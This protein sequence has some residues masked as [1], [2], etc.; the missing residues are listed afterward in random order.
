MRVDRGRLEADCFSE[1][2]F[3]LLGVP[4]AHANGAKVHE[5]TALVR[6]NLQRLLNL[7]DR[8]CRIFERG[9]GVRT[10]EERV[11]VFRI[12][13]QQRRRT[14]LRILEAASKEQDL[15][16]LDL[17]VAIVWQRIR[18]SN[19]LGKGGPQVVHPLVRFRE[20]Q[21]RFTELRIEPHRVGVFDDRK[22]VA[23]FGGVLIASLEMTL[24]LDFLVAAGERQ[25]GERN[26]KDD[27]R[28]RAIVEDHRSSSVLAYFKRAGSRPLTYR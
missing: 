12:P 13:G 24:F 21:A 28:L 15:R 9:K 25:E 26:Q 16:R 1:G 19:E 14:S 23:L 4:A 3:R 22:L 11:D 27:A 6:L 10:Q 5:G 18:G 17:G 8:A 20:L 2:G 7:G